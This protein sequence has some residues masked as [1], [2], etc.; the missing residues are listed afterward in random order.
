MSVIAL[1]NPVSGQGSAAD[2]LTAVERICSEAGA[3]LKVLQSS[4]P[5]VV[6]RLAAE[7]ARLGPERLLVVGG[8]GT[9]GEVARAYADLPTDARPPVVIVPAGRGNSMYRALL[10]D[11]PWQGYVRRVLETAEIHHVDAAQVAET[12]DAWVLGFSVGYLAESVHA[13]RFFRGLRGRTS[14]AAGGL[15]AAVRLRP[16]PVEVV[17]DGRPVYAGRSVLVGLAG[18]PF[19]GGR[20]LLYPTSDLTDGLLDVV[21][22]TGVSSRRFTGVLRAAAGGRHV[23]MDEVLTFR[24]AEV[25]IASREPARC[26]LDGTPFK[27]PGDTLTIKCLPGVLPVAYPASEWHELRRD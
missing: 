25:R 10:A 22:V 21:I 15:Y 4:G 13:T 19:R 7:A 24:G 9:L 11:A 6:T 1:V 18:G 16:F 23:E 3:D 8:D 5:G 17:V 12:G 14:Y 20:L 26:E 27:A 2:Q